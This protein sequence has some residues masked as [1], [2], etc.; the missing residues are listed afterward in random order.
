MENFD[1]DM[2]ADQ[3][4]EDTQLFGVMFVLLSKCNHRCVHCYI[5]EHASN[6]LPAEVIC[7]A[8]DEARDLGALNVTFT[9]GEILLRNDLLDLI[10]YARS[11]F[12][13]VFLMS[14]GYALDE[15][16]IQKLAQ[17]HIS[18]FS[19]TVYSM[20][21]SIHDRITKVPGSFNRTLR[22]IELLKQN[23][24]DITVKT[25][26]MEYNK[27]SYR[28]VETFAR[29]NGFSFRTTPTI[30]SKTTGER[31]PHDYEITSDLQ[32]IVRETDL[33]NQRYRGELVTRNNG[34]IPCSAGHSN[35]CINYD[36]TVW[37]CNTLTLDVGN[38]L[39]HS[40]TEIWT[41]S[42]RLNDWRNRCKQIPEECLRCHLYPQCIRCPGLAFMED[43]NLFGCSTSAKRVA[44]QRK[45]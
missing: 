26:L 27:Y 5:P 3:C 28:D 36:G 10:A 19:T 14:N 7:R 44:E 35:I 12:M 15:E 38:I 40:L 22:N 42:S 21:S 17:L 41:N 20:D 45:I 24:I 34:E 29:D 37:P 4:L 32:M 31:T 43:G 23:N 9:G 6:G 1:I 13:R 30:F 11:K 16:Y 25:P 39:E 18:E 8:I 33:L 2:L